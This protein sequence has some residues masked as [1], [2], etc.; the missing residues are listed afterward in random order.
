VGPC[1]DGTEISGSIKG[2][3]FERVTISVSRTLL[4]GVSLVSVRT[5]LVT[6]N[7]TV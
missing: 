1:E 6:H 4:D 7:L 5:I 3:K 2:G